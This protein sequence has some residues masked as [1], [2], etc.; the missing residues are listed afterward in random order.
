MV[1]SLSGTKKVT[2]NSFSD[3]LLRQLNHPIHHAE[4]LLK[5][6]KNP[7]SALV[8][9]IFYRLGILFGSAEA[10]IFSA[11]TVGVTKSKKSQCGKISGQ[12]GIYQKY[13]TTL[14]VYFCRLHRKLYC[15]HKIALQSFNT[16]TKLSMPL[17]T[18]SRLYNKFIKGVKLW[19]TSK[20]RIS[21]AI[22]STF[23]TKA[24]VKKFSQAC[25]CDINRKIASVSIL[26]CSTKC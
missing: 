24:D 10:Q 4:T 15:N 11:Y 23:L 1:G 17:T 6:I 19:Q 16:T 3:Q 13:E 14:L 22:A 12:K 2:S 7:N 9:D 8:A 21:P 20:L 5:P 26:C 25:L 18:W